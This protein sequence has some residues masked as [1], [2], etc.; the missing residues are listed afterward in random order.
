VPDDVKARY[1][2]L[3]KGVDRLFGVRNPELAHV[4]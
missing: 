2:A 3:R 4:P 1:V